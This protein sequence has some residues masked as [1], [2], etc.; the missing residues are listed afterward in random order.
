M[1]GRIGLG[2]LET[3]L[4]GLND[5]SLDLTDTELA[6]VA[7]AT[8][9]ETVGVTGL[10][11]TT[12]GLTTGIKAGV[13]SSALAS[14]LTQGGLINDLHISG[15]NPTWNVNFGGS[16]AGQSDCSENLLTSA[17]TMLQLSYALEG[18]AKQTAVVSAAQATAIFG[19]SGVT[20]V[21]YA[22]A[23]GTPAS[24]NLKVV[25]LTGNYDDV[26]LVIPDL[27]T[28]K[29]QTLFIFTDNVVT[30]GGVLTF[31]MNA[32][33]EFDAESSELFTSTDGGTVMTKTALTDDHIR[34]VLTDTGASTML[35]GSF[36]YFQ[37]NADT[38]TMTVKACIRT[39]GGTIAITEANS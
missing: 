18:V 10:T 2:H 12:G 24:A 19:A 1:A 15:L 26:A 25:R 28:D 23:A 37:A 21:D 36:V 13:A 6:N 39:S 7:A 30:A 14:G 38:D 17:N 22:V 29:H 32:A 8:F 27:A 33:N 11:T 16:L 34:L 35:A 4:E 20:G 9:A 31:G 3:L 5:R